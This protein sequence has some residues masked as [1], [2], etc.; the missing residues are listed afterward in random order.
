M[1]GARF[2]GFSTRQRKCQDHPPSAD[3]SENHLRFTVRQPTGS[4]R[5]Y[6]CQADRRAARSAKTW[7]MKIHASSAIENSGSPIIE[8]RDPMPRQCWRTWPAR[9]GIHLQQHGDDHY[10]DRQADRQDRPGQSPACGRWPGMR[11][12]RTGRARC[13][14]HFTATQRQVTLKTAHRGFAGAVPAV[15]VYSSRGPH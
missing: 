1:M 9:Q 7:R 4:G 10:P 8:Q 11:R 6:S 3:S 5:R 15:L 2:Q 14:R 13:R 12:A